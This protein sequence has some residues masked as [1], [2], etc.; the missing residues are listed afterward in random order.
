MYCKTTE[1]RKLETRRGTT[2]TFLRTA[3][4]TR[5]ISDHHHAAMVY[6]DSPIDRPFCLLLLSLSLCVYALGSGAG[7][8]SP[9]GAGG[10]RPRLTERRGPRRRRSQKNTLDR[11]SWPVL[12]NPRVHAC[13]AGGGE[14]REGDGRDHL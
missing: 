11:P 13:L 1:K 6:C 2:E 5:L 4:I 10:S 7:T 12:A 3:G 8:R 9:Q 14:G